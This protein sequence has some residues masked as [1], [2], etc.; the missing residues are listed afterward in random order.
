LKAS[1]PFCLSAADVFSAEDETGGMRRGGAFGRGGDGV[2]A[3]LRD[4]A[5]EVVWRKG[6]FDWTGTD[7]REDAAEGV[8]SGENK[9]T[10]GWG[11]GV[12]FFRRAGLTYV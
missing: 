11:W 8:G 12:V 3:G 6:L 5:A 4:L 7:W 1:E 2:A 10:S 9:S